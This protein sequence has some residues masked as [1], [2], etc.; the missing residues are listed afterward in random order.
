MEQNG[1]GWG[2]PPEESEVHIGVDFA[3]GD[4]W[5]EEVIVPNQSFTTE[6]DT[7]EARGYTKGLAFGA[8]IAKEA[9]DL[10]DGRERKEA[11]KMIEARVENAQADSLATS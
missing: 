5:S 1:N 3:Y 10:M 6:M 2:E 4:S 7:L 9:A 8:Q 11:L